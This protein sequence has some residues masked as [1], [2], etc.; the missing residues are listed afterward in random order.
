MEDESIYLI[1]KDFEVKSKGSY[2]KNI[3]R[4]KV[5]TEDELYLILEVKAKEEIA[6][7]EE[8]REFFAESPNYF[9]QVL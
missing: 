4:E 7:S 1:H 6:R 9:L 5:V 8:C 2:Y 3:K